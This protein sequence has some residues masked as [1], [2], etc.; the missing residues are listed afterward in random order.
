MARLLA[1]FGH[2][3][4]VANPRKLKLISSS[5]RKDD[6][7]DA[8]LLARLARVDP[9]L[10]HPVRHLGERA[11]LHLLAIRARA[12]LVDARTSLVNAARGL[13]KSFGE[14][15]ANCDASQMC[16]EQTAS[17]PAGM[18]DALRPLLEEVA[19]LTKRIEV[20][21]KQIEQIAEDEYPET[22][23]LRQVH[24]VGA[25]IGCCMLESA[26]A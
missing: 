24:G 11:Q 10:L 9:Q 25:L 4:F 3:V 12:G 17:L 2:E 21:D 19:A 7:M 8:R 18:Q 16:V 14:R 20:Y 5:S 6:R 22:E 1:T 26:F 15:L 23:L 13:V